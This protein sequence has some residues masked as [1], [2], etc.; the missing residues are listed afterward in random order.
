MGITGAQPVSPRTLHQQILRLPSWV[1][2]KYKISKRG[3]C[4]NG[5][6]AKRGAS[7]RG[8]GGSGFSADG[9]IP[10]ASAQVG[11]QE[12]W[13][14]TTEMCVNNVNTG[15]DPIHPGARGRT[16]GVLGDVPVDQYLSRHGTRNDRLWG[17]RIRAANPRNL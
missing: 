16:K 5:P 14:M 12:C 9:G 10:A 17:P 13:T 4:R 2:G 11:R 15:S 8:G 6:R 7:K 3:R 1:A